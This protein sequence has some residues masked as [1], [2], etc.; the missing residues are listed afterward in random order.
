MSKNGFFYIPKDIEWDIP[1][2]SA[3]SYRISYVK[4]TIENIPMDILVD[5]PS[6]KYMCVVCRFR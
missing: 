2:F 6:L 4:K 1:I 3:I 5:I